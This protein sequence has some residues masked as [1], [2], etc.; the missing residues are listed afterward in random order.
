MEV[1]VIFS[2]RFSFSFRFVGTVIMV[3]LK[4][5]RFW[6]ILFNNFL[7]EKRTSFYPVP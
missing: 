7:S 5:T 6:D 3:I 1:L 2:P 4:Q